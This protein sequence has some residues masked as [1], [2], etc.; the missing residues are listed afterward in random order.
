[1]RSEEK[2]V[3]DMLLNAPVIIP[4]VREIAEVAG[5]F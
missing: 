4:I 3:T 5:R 2:H 1:M